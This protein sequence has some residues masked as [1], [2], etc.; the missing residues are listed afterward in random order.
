[1]S[2]L[3]NE[4]F[5]DQ[6]SHDSYKSALKS[7]KTLFDTISTP[8]N[9]IV[10]FGCG[11]APWLSAAQKLGVKSICGT[12]GD[13]VPRDRL[14]IPQENFVPNDL[15]R[16]SSLELPVNDFD[17]AISLEVAEHLPISSA[18]GF[19][20]QLCN[21]SDIVLFSA[22]IP[23]QGGHGHINENWPEYWA[24][25]FE[26]FGY[27]AFD[28]IRPQIWK[29]PDICWWYKQN[30]IVF[31]KSEKRQL[32]LPE[33]KP[34]SK[35]QLSIIHPEQFLVSVHRS[36]STIK[37]G[38]KHD[39]KYWNN[40][41]NE[42]NQSYYGSE[43]SYTADEPSHPV[44]T[45]ND[46]M[47]SRKRDVPLIKDV[48]SRIEPNT[49]LP[50]NSLINDKQVGRSPDFLCIGVQNSAT[51]WLY[52]LL[53]NQ[54]EIWV[55]PIKEINYFNSMYFK[56]SSA[57]SGIWRRKTALRRLK[58]AINNND[59]INQ[60]WLDLLVL[61][62]REEVDEDW[63]KNIFSYA[64]KRKKC[65]EISP[66]YSML[67]LDAIEHI[68]KSNPNLKIILI[69]RSPIERA[70]SHLKSIKKIEPLLSEKCSHDITKQQS[71]F[72]RGNYPKIIDKWLSVFPRE[73]IHI[74]F[75]EKLKHNPELFLDKLSQFLECNID[76][77]KFIK[78][79]VNTSKLVLE[80]EDSLRISLEAQ[81]N[82]TIN[83]M[84]KRYPE[85]IELWNK[86]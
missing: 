84:N 25:L 64:P 74:D 77:S 7:L 57:Y 40:I 42:E 51:T 59:N 5:Y 12:D 68:Y 36:N 52:Q 9:S 82:N 62:T 69:L 49:N 76:G 37:N 58:Q 86:N 65:G 30:L 70:I 83:E 67:S 72:E 32:I 34:T 13:Y 31:V 56:K 73:Q 79:W 21:N 10:D 55:P 61:L 60:N 6:Q 50:K 78:N 47:K 66:D 3:Y 15:S 4:S 1:M 38:L 8:I 28:I 54:H 27:D 19:I 16:P 23:Y 43:F 24:T 17:L 33:I 26:N 2:K 22:A 39:V 41:I 48:L 18:K 35:E 75:Q 71:V 11:V 81:F 14:L 46:L 80:N 20:Q 85:T 63:Y 44:E 45:I 29:D 53:Q